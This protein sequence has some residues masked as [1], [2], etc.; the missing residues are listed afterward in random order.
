MNATTV[1]DIWRAWWTSLSGPLAGLFWFGGAVVAAIAARRAATGLLRLFRFDRLCESVGIAAFLRTGRV[2]YTPAR[3]VGVGV[4]WLLLLGGVLAA[5]RRATPEMTG[6]LVARLAHFAPAF[7][8]A[9]A[10]LVAGLR[11]GSFAAKFVY[12]LACNAGSPYAELLARGIRVAGGLLV[13][14][15]AAEQMEIG[16]AII[17]AVVI[18]LLAAAGLALALAFGLGCRDLARE[19]VVRFLREM[20][21]RARAAGQNDLEG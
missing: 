1:L 19:A 13:I 15:A 6:R 21:E 2:S 14:A 7:M 4:F 20:R 9:I 18:T 5:A 8:A 16:R 10:I 17:L 11:L 3:L 12:T